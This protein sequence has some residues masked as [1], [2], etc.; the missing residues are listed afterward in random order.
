MNEVLPIE[1]IRDQFKDEWVIM[2]DLVVEKGPRVLA[3]RVIEH[4]KDRDEIDRKLL[5]LRPKDCAVY[6]LGP[7]PPPGME[8]L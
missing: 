5:E 8:V 4:S 1:A 6:Y 2:I 3:G 7:I